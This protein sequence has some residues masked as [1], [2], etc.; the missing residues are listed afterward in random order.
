MKTNVHFRDLVEEQRSAIGEL[1]FS[2]FRRDSAGKGTAFVA[3]KLAL[4]EVLRNRSAVDR[5]KRTAPARAVLVNQASN[6]FL[7]RSAFTLNENRGSGLSYGFRK[8]DQFP[9]PTVR[10]DDFLHADALLGVR[11]GSKT[12]DHFFFM[13]PKASRASFLQKSSVALEAS[14]R[15]TSSAL[16]DAPSPSCFRKERDHS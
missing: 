8:S 10:R 14:F 13:S 11:L 9:H 3:K 1:E 5:N 2:G 7:A 6:Q 12:Q 16:A 15:S 4:Q